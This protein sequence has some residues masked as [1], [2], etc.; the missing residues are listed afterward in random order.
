MAESEISK[1]EKRV[2]DLIDLCDQLSTENT[3]LRERQNV[4]VEERARLIEKAEL[5]RSRVETMLERLKAME[6]E[7]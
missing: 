5:A 1:L 2:D 4:L 3:L 6:V 7:A